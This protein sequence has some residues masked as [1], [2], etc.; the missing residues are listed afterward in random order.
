MVSYHVYVPLLLRLANDVEENPGPINIH[1]IVDHSFTVRADFNQVNA[2]NLYAIISQHVLKDFLL[3]TDVP[4]IL[5]INN[6][7]FNSEYSDSFSGALWMEYNNEPLLHLNMLF[8][9]CNCHG[10]DIPFELKGVKCHRNISLS[11]SLGNTL[12]E[13]INTT[14]NNHEKCSQKRQSETITI[15]KSNQRTKQQEKENK[16]AKQREKR[17]QESVAERKNRLAMLREKRHQESV[18]ERENR[19]AN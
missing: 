9:N 8:M 13:R 11:N 15:R 16:L 4:E 18:A 10:Q 17:Q 12:N 19:L 14:S 7:T 6:D 1:D 2:N 5:S 3:L